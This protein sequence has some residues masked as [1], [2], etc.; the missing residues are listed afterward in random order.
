MTHHKWRNTE[1]GMAISPFFLPY[2]VVSFYTPRPLLPL[3]PS[4]IA[5]KKC[6]RSKYI[7]LT[8]KNR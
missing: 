4:F 3:L 2:G 6:K 8:N 5:R 7:T 1:D